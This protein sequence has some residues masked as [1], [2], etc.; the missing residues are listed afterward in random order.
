M[1]IQ[2]MQSRDIEALQ[3][4]F[5]DKPEEQFAADYLEQLQ[6][7]RTVFVAVEKDDEG[8]RTYFGYVTILWQSDYTQFWRRNIPEIVDLQV[9]EPYRK[10]GIG[11][12]LIAACETYVREKGYTTIGVCVE[13]NASCAAA[14]RLYPQLGY[15]TDSFGST[16]ADS[17]LHLIKTL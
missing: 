7:I 14:N 5:P 9:A 8:T 4:L 2:K 11:S 15:T 10:Q 13:Q 17:E 16:H 1:P 12:A 6:D 3:E